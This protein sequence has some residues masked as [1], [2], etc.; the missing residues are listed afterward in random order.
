MIVCKTGNQHD[1]CVTCRRN[2]MLSFGTQTTL[3]MSTA[4]EDN[5]TNSKPPLSNATFC[6]VHNCI[7][8]DEKEECIRIVAMLTGFCKFQPSDESLLVI[9]VVGDNT[10]LSNRQHDAC[11]IDVC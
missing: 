8:M 4:R 1:E 2:I 9:D 6:C 10:S 7:A 3:G 5:N 11:Q